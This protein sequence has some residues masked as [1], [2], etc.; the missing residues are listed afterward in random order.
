MNKQ[1]VITELKNRICILTLNEPEQLNAISDEM[2]VVFK[3]TIEKLKADNKPK[4]LV[5]TGAGRAFSSGGNLSEIESCFGS[6]PGIRKRNIFDFYN[7]FLSVRTL[8]IPTIAAINGYA[9]GAG[10]CL[11]I[12][13]NM[14]IAAEGAKIGF[15]FAK[16]GLHPGMGAEYLLL[17]TVGEAKTYE[18]LMTGDIIPAAEAHRIGL[19]NHVVPDDKLMDKAMELA[20]KICAIPD[21]PIKMMKDSI[22]A[23]KNCTLAETLHRQASYQAINYMTRDV[24][25]GI[26]ALREKRKPNFQ[27]DY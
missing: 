10:A 16:L 7:R 27:D 25:E 15:P 23:A 8:R 3:K 24:K 19:V 21:L 6:E 12:A 2:S 13:C 11:A 5:I 20:N 26:N 17:N 4:V 9:I 1:P 18:L 22:P 14:R